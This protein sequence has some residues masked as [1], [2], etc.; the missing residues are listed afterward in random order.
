MIL[1]LVLIF[2]VRIFRPIIANDSLTFGILF[3]LAVIC[4][5]TGQIVSELIIIG[6]SILSL[7][8]S[9]IEIKKS[10]KC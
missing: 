8:I 5:M 4:L 6:Y 9:L 2:L 7:Y 10:K 3:L 1:G